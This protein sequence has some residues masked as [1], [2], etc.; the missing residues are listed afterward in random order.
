LVDLSSDAVERSSAS[1]RATDVHDRYEPRWFKAAQHVD[2]A[3]AVRI[4]TDVDATRALGIHWGTFQLTDEARDAPVEGLT[5]A[6]RAAGI[7]RDRFVA[8]EAGDVYSFG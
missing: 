6:L 4:F 7:A 1:L 3:E 2:P 8:A 5:T